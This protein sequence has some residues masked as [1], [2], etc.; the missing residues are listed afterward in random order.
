MKLSYLPGLLALIG[1]GIVCQPSDRS[2]GLTPEAGA[3]AGLLGLNSGGSGDSSGLTSA[4]SRDFLEPAE[5]ATSSAPSEFHYDTGRTVALRVSGDPAGAGALYTV[6]ALPE[7]GNSQRLK[8]GVA[9]S[10][11]LFSADLRISGA[12][13]RL[14]ITRREA[15][16]FRTQFL[17]LGDDCAS[18]RYLS[19]TS[20]TARLRI[21]RDGANFE[22]PNDV[23]YAVNNQGDVITIDPSTDDYT[24]TI[25]ASLPVTGSI[26]NAI[27]VANRRMYFQQNTALYYMDMNTNSFHEVGVLPWR[28]PR[29]EYNANDGLLYMGNNAKLYLVDPLRAELL[30]TYNIDGIENPV[31]GGDLKYDA[32]GV[33]YMTAF[34]GLY[35]LGDIVEGQNIQATR[36]SG[37]NLPFSPTSLTIDSD[38]VLYMGENSGNAKFIAMSTAN[39][40]YQQLA[41]YPFAINDLSTLPRNDA[42]LDNTDSDNDGIPDY[43]DEYPND[44]NRAFEQFTPSQFGFGT[45]AFEDL[46]PNQGDYD[47]NDLVVNYRFIAVENSANE[48][49][50][51][52]AKL[53]V[54]AIGAAYRN[55]FG[56]QLPIAPERVASV[57][58]QRLT[59]NIITNNA[60]GTEAGQS[61]AVIVIFDDADQRVISRRTGTPAVNSNEFE[62]SIV[63]TT[64]VPAAELGAAPFNPFLIVNGNRSREVHLQN[65][66]PTDLAAPGL[67]GQ[68][69]D[70]SPSGVYYRSATGHP[71]AIDIVH[72]FKFPL[73]RV[74]I[75][76][77]YNFFRSWVNAAGSAHPDWYTDGAGRRNTNKLHIEAVDF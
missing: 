12:V 59:R 21:Q 40:D 50:E 31:T 55:G 48:V 60:N 75:E 67:F 7:N 68:G 64:P 56:V 49:V 24:G 46:W 61:K 33:L 53:R 77:G 28:V 58:G 73:E 8:S 52:K 70:D 2:S 69:D 38:G 72:D 36:I 62:V 66:E 13:N 63:F 45:V 6:Y 34:S 39:G 57:S 29:M 9:A 11:G 23:L 30:A 5:C 16:R 76:T 27:D 51:L 41:Q 19:D 74:H 65:H 15:G 32:N 54:R 20:A 42:F 4:V 25:I 71:W 10:S 26:T 44:A 37:D 3:L 47:F 17:E 35:R 1:L 18:F 43:N 14:F 22:N